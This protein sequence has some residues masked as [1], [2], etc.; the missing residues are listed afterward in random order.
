MGFLSVALSRGRHLKWPDIFK[1]LLEFLSKLIPYLD[2]HFVAFIGAVILVLIVCFSLLGLF[3][4]AEGALE[5]SLHSEIILWS[6]LVTIL[7]SLGSLMILVAAVML[8]VLRRRS[9]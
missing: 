3:V 2:R 5:E 4:F 8:F 1:P 9:R 7:I 6:V